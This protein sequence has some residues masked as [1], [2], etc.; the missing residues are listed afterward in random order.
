MTCSSTTTSAA[1]A[2]R[3][4]YWIF[5]AGLLLAA[6]IAPAAADSRAVDQA[7]ARARAALAAA[8]GIAAEARLRE[9]RR[10]GAGDDVLRAAMGEALLAQGDLVRARQW[11]APA[12]FSPATRGRG[13][14]LLGQLEL[15]EGRLAQAGAAF[16][17]A[18]AIAP[19]DAGLWTDIARLRLAGGEDQGALQAAERAVA[20]GPR[21]VGALRLRGEL[22]RRQQGYAAALPWFDAALRIAPGDPSLL[23]ERAATLA[24]LGRY[25]EALAAM[26]AAPRGA[27][28]DPRL[29]FQQAVIAARGGNRSL[30]R[31]ILARAGKGLDD[32]PGALLLSAAL[33]LDAGNLNAATAAADRVL[34]R[35]PANAAA[36][37]LLAQA[38]ARRGDAE[39][40]LARFAA[41]AEGG[42]ASVYLTSIVAR[43]FEETGRRDRAVALLTV[44]ATP[45][46]S[47]TARGPVES[48]AARLDFGSGHLLRLDRDLRGRGRGLDADLLALAFAA[49]HPQDLAAVRN[50]ANV[51]ARNR[52]WNESARLYEWLLLRGGGNDP[53]LLADL[54]L[55]RWRQ[56]QGAAAREL[57]EAAARLQPASPTVRS[58]VRMTVPPA[59]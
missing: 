29:I 13:F 6:L 22:V 42:G 37:D 27:P 49:E 50:L 19:A 36:Q 38:M 39:A 8:D 4:R 43:A 31:R 2:R 47:R 34:R 44:A 3:P 9:A 51:R 12:R 56:G 54:A 53:S 59:N 57:A 15:R 24:E 5:A 17:Q 28:G 25:G 23:A 30:A 21:N 46:G 18:L 33:E 16:D 1:E 7:L 58:I 10:A 26:R 32:L 48:G 14:R 20:L 55:V 40:V 41:V 11:L 45:P 35:Q 52:Q